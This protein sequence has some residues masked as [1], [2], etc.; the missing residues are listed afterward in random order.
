METNPS[1]VEPTQIRGQVCIAS[2]AVFQIDGFA[3]QGSCSGTGLLFLVGSLA[4]LYLHFHAT[5]SVLILQH[6]GC[7]VVGFCFLFY[8]E[9]SRRVE[10]VPFYLISRLIYFILIQMDSYFCKVINTSLKCQM[11]FELG[12]IFNP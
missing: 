11:L 12:D 8:I 9:S 7:T 3:L 2:D 5:A 1:W 4:H 6:Y 10:Q